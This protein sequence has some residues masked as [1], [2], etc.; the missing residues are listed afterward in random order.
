MK[1]EHNT[2]G[3]QGA[4][5]TCWVF[6]KGFDLFQIKSGPAAGTF[7]PLASIVVTDQSGVEMKVLLW[8]RAAL[9][10][11]TVCPG[12]ILLISGKVQHR[13]PAVWRRSSCLL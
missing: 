5:R 7:V 10:V 3:H 6:D 13:W 8:R 11:L 9:W 4:M 12:D 2:F 1:S